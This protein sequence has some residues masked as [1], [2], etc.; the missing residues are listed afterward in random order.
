MPLPL[1]PLLLTISDERFRTLNALTPEVRSA[2]LEAAM[3]AYGPPPAPPGPAAPPADELRTLYATHTLMQIGAHL[4]VS[5]M[6]ARKWLRAAGVVMR[7]R[8]AKAP[9]QPGNV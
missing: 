3:T 4:G 5:P 9:A 2:Y 6:T 8:G 1:R 7:Q